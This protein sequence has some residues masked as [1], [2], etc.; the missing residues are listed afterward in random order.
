MNKSFEELG[1]EERIQ[2]VDT[3]ESEFTAFADRMSHELGIS[4]HTVRLMWVALYGRD[5]ST[6]RKAGIVLVMPNLPSESV[7]VLDLN[8]VVESEPNPTIR[9]IFHGMIE[10]H[11]ATARQ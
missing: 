1:A 10:A 2:A 9:H 7:E 8:S 5:G 4:T 6:K 11:K 3:V